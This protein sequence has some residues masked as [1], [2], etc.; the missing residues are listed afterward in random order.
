MRKRFQENNG[1]LLPGITTM[2]ET[3]VNESYTH[4]SILFFKNA[5]KAIADVPASEEMK[6]YKNAIIDQMV[7]SYVE[8]IDKEIVQKQTSRF[9][10]KQ[11]KEERAVR[12]AARKKEDEIHELRCKSAEQVLKNIKDGKEYLYEGADHPMLCVGVKGKTDYGDVPALLRGVY[13]EP[14]EK[15]SKGKKITRV[16][17]KKAAKKVKKKRTATKRKKATS[18]ISTGKPSSMPKKLPY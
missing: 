5:I 4:K 18:I 2:N 15:K 11:E 1:S 6:Q 7:D 10:E 3:I 8:F 17:A 16:V 14:E 12:F 13:V 9:Y